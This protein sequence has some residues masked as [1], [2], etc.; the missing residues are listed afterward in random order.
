MTAAVMA[1]GLCAG[2]RNARPSRFVAAVALGGLLASCSHDDTIKLAAPFNENTIVGEVSAVWSNTAA[3]RGFAGGDR[4]KEPEVRFRYRLDVRSK[5]GDKLF[6]RL[7]GFELVG[8]NGLPL[9]SDQTNV[10]CIVGSGATPAILQGDV[11]IPKRV[12]GSV[13]AFRVSHLA[14][15]LSDRGRALYREWLLQGRPGA[16]AEIDA[17][18]AR[19]AA[20]PACVS[21]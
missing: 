9:G 2:R 10:E 19:H 15:P 13:K 5:L 21:H 1:P 4:L 12:A 7:G 20:A 14:I 11:W 3:E 8:E 6:V 16:A 17:E 18:I